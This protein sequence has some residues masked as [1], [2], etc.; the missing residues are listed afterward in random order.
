MKRLNLRDLRRI[1]REEIEDHSFNTINESF[2]KSL[3]GFFS[4]ESSDQKDISHSSENDSTKPSPT[5]L[6][7]KKWVEFYKEGVRGED[8][9]NNKYFKWL[10]QTGSLG[11]TN[12]YI[13]YAKIADDSGEPDIN[14]NFY[15]MGKLSSQVSNS[16]TAKEPLDKSHSKETILGRGANKSAFLSGKSTLQ[17]AGHSMKSFDDLERR[18]QTENLRKVIRKIIRGL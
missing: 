16:S 10:C 1:I 14:D 18:V 9:L 4:S 12:K 13:C 3:N 5:N 17:D 7:S 6:V 11:S 8:I 2:W 15:K